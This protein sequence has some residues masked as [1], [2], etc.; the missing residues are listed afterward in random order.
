M[1]P[2]DAEPRRYLLRPAGVLTQ[3]SCAA[4]L[5]LGTIAFVLIQQNKSG[6]APLAIM[7]AIG[8]MAGLVFGGL[9]SRGG[10]LSLFVSAALTATFGIVLIAI[11]YDTLREILRVLPESDVEMV[12]DVMVV[13]AVV[14]L[15]TSAM[16]LA[17]I[18]QARRYARAYARAVEEAVA[19]DP[20]LSAAF[21]AVRTQPALPPAPAPA[22]FGPAAP[23]SGTL[24]QAAKPV[25]P[26]GP[27]LFPENST[28]PGNRLAPL[29]QDRPTDPVGRSIIPLHPPAPGA[30]TNEPVI[31]RGPRTE[32]GFATATMDDR[33]TN[34]VGRPIIPPGPRTAPGIMATVPGGGPIAPLEEQAAGPDPGA[35]NRG[36]TPAKTGFT[37]QII[38]RPPKEEARSRRRIYIAL[39]GF[40]IGLGAGIGVLVTSGAETDSG[41]ETASGSGS[42]SASGTGSA[43]AAG[44][45]QAA[46]SGSVS[47]TGP[48]GVSGPDGVTGTGSASP[49]SGSGS[50]SV[51]A[52]SGSD[53]E[54][55]GT[56]SVPIRTLITAQREAIAKGDAKAYAA[57]L[58]PG[59]FAFG[60]EGDDVAEGRD[61]IEAMLAKHL[62]D[63]PASGF[64]VSSKFLATGGTGNVAWTAEDIEVG[65]RRIAITQVAVFAN[66]AWSVVALCWGMPVADGTAERMA[67]LGTLPRAAAVPNKHDGSDELDKAVRIAFSSRTAFAAAR[68]ER[69]DGFNFGS[70]PG[71]RVIGGVAIKR[72]FG[73]LRSELKLDG[74]VRASEIAPGVGWA[75]LNAV[76]TSKSRAAT[77]VSQTFRV[78][79][80]LVKEDG[81]WKIVQTQFSNAG[82]IRD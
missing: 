15:V 12:G 68:S 41:S 3:V 39:G 32:P 66:G 45:G 73:R 28:Q 60:L 1:P 44:S 78:L 38:V 4:C 5:L 79:A 49:A 30:P 21:S 74:G 71:E 63:P 9:M 82:P 19:A 57:T 36:W 56:P 55:A 11:D 10:L 29:A 61:A 80:V 25:A 18:G 65:V 7:W 40:A 27:L 54:L 6:G 50:A 77:D 2:E 8:A 81:A 51:S 37:T 33:P 16:C 13:G 62:A 26:S 14:M 47:D 34:P 64:P 23:G 35:T 17:S 59:A 46:A 53:A 24:P 58:A 67:I 76:Y 75:A 42:G 22:S 69:D 43:S 52:A 48:A 72:L 20:S 31:P 70:G